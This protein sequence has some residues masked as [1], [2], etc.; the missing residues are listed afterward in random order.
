MRSGAGVEADGFG[1]FGLAVVEGP[2]TFRFQLQGA[3]YME[4]VKCA[5]AEGWAE[6][7]GQVDAGLPY[8]IRKFDMNP[9]S[10]DTVVF[11]LLPTC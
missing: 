5:D 8:M 3:G 9:D 1:E 2:E 6:A 10:S 11:E 4:G 7:A